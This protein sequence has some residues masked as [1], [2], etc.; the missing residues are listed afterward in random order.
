MKGYMK[1]T[2]FL[3]HIAKASLLYVYLYL[4]LFPMQVKLK[5]KE[6]FSFSELSW[7]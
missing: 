6:Y 4:H 5:S 2:N 3:R 7:K 1:R